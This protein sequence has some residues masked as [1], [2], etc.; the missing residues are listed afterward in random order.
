MVDWRGD[1]ALRVLRA[2][3]EL[4]AFYGQ[5]IPPEQLLDAWGW[6][7]VAEEFGS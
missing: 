1:L 2:I 6:E 7:R 5:T 4:R 3:G